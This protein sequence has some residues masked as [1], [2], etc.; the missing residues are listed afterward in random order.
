MPSQGS[1]NG[2]RD[3]GNRHDRTVSNMVRRHT[4]HEKVGEEIDVNRSGEHSEYGARLRTK[5]RVFSIR[6]TTP[7]HIMVQ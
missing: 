5:G 2:E 4:R 1:A 3:C 6:Q 7:E